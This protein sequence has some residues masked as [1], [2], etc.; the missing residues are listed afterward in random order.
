MGK[1]K[2][3]I[4][5]PVFNGE[6]TIEYTIAS[7]MNQMKSYYEII[8]VD[9][10][11]TD[12][13]SVICDQVGEENNNVQ[14]IHQKNAGS[15][16]ARLSGVK[17]AKGDYIVYLDA[18]DVIL[19][20]GLENIEKY[21]EKYHADIY[22]Y[23]Y[24]M[25]KIGG[26]ETSV[27]RL[28]D[29]NDI[30]SWNLLNKKEIMNYFYEGKLNN[31]ATTV[32]SRKILSNLRSIKCEGKIRIGEDRLQLLYTLL[33]SDVVMYIPE[34]F[35]HY[36]WRNNSQ[37]GAVRSGMAA[38]SM[39]DDFKIVW[40][41]ERNSYSIAGFAK[42]EYTK[43]DC[44]KLSRIAS[45]VEGIYVSNSQL[46]RKEK[47]S[48]VCKLSTDTLFQKLATQDNVL[49]LRLYIKIIIILVK[50][51]R[52]LFLE[53][54]LKGCRLIKGLKVYIR[55]QYSNLIRKLKCR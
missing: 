33:D 39:Y 38:P 54:Y 34:C 30:K 18:D 4:I 36:K 40:K 7:V 55:N 48:F 9:D 22:I 13:S 46:T 44:Q 51:Q 21:I 5:I 3:S 37:G 28:L 47:K 41:H 49:N 31:I 23:D 42:E 11:S 27:K 16:E 17:V 1:Y 20:N 24:L 43:Y 26:K 14:V 52:A 32:V 8:L 10:G 53:T 50:K 12:N 35:Y 45:L 25:D 29:Y 6:A 15:L 19:S 2:L